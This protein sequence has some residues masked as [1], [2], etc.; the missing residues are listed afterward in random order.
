MTDSSAK[1][2]Q[3]LA[4]VLVSLFNY[5]V[6]Q[7]L[8]TLFLPGSEFLG[9]LTFS[10]VWLGVALLL[11]VAAPGRFEFLRLDGQRIWRNWRQLTLYVALAAGGLLVFSLLGFT[12][13]FKDVEYPLLFVVLIPL[14]EELVFRGYVFTTLQYVFPRS[15]VVASAL[16][17]ALHHAQYYGFDVSP[18]LLFQ[19]AYT[20]ALG[21]VLAR[22][23]QHSGSVYL[24][25]A[26]HCCINFVA[27]QW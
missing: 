24:G 25:I 18:F 3:G 26:L 17:F 15:A 6:A 14:I 9:E 19:I 23:R 16:L 5:V 11:C 13:F 7:R 27:L 12:R 2:L 1:V 20:F 4:V 8:H 21:V 22:I 10:L